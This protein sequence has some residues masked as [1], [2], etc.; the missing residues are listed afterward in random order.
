[1]SLSPS[2]NTLPSSPKTHNSHPL[3]NGVLPIVDSGSI[4]NFKA[5]AKKE[6]KYVACSFLHGKQARW[7]GVGGAGCASWLSL[8]HREGPELCMSAEGFSTPTMAAVKR[9]INSANIEVRKFLNST[10]ICP[11]VLGL[12]GGHNL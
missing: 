10:F 7:T 8:S 9:S 1:M 6:I 11:S 2:R 5:S 4:F 3:I 12:K